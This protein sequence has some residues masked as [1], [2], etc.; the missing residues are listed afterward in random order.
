MAS[1]TG[2]GERVNPGTVSAAAIREYLDSRRGWVRGVEWASGRRYLPARMSDR[3]T[4]LYLIAYSFRDQRAARQ[5]SLAV[6]Q[7]WSLAPESCRE[8]YDAILFQAAGLIVIQLRRSNLCGCLGHRHPLVRE[9]PFAEPHHSLGSV[10]VGEMDLAY[11]H[12]EAWQALPL[13]DTALDARFLEGSR[14]EDFRK[15]QFRLKA[16]SVILHETHHLV[17]PQEPET[18]IRQRSVGFYHDTIAHYVEN[19]TA[20]LSLTIDRSFYRFG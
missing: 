13:S 16:L 11:R 5:L 12:I 15:K 2:T 6:E 3:A 17:C 8:A 7:D 4:P 9:K 20:T 10:A 14:L 1:A 18:A 19:A